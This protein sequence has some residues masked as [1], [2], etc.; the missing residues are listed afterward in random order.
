MTSAEFIRCLVQKHLSIKAGKS[1]KLTAD[2]DS[3]ENMWL[4]V[5][6]LGK[7]E[8]FSY[9][10]G[11]CQSEID[12]YAWL[13]QTKGA[14]AIAEADLLFEQMQCQETNLNVEEHTAPRLLTAAQHQHW[15]EWGYLKISGLVPAEYC[16]RV[17]AFTCNYLG[18]NLADPTTWY[19]VHK[20][21]HG[22]ML[23][24]YQ[25]PD[26][27]AIRRHPAVK[28]LFAELYQTEKIVANTDKVSYNPPETEQWRFRHHRLHWD[29]DH[30]QSPGYYIQGLIYLDDV[31]EDR[32]PLKL[33]P[34]F[35]RRY[36]EYQRQFPD[37]MAAQNA[38]KEKSGAIPIPGKLGD[39]VLW[40]QMLPHAASINQS[41]KPR[42]VQYLSFTRLD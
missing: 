11:N 27:E 32:G 25:H 18:I 6:G 13:Q 20:D 39:I 9:L 40:Q 3:L 2:L 15:Q 12:F 38:I 34:G 41:D 5:Y 36:D 4:A 26:M 31:P 8:I 19:P 10:Y 23:Q 30:H 24:V 7:L 21:W 14:T 42:F 16:E 28:Q 29:I 17:K 37:H 35:H 33:I 22:L 1:Y